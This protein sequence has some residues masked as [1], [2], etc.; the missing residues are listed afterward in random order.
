M[1]SKQLDFARILHFTVVRHIFIVR[2]I[3]NREDEMG[4]LFLG[5]LLLNGI[6]PYALKA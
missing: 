6:A 3:L 5:L 2:H 4:R 1:T